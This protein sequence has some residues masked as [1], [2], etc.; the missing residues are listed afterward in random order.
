MVSANL[1]W[2]VSCR[3]DGACVL[4]TKVDKVRS[5]CISSPVQVVDPVSLLVGALGLIVVILECGEPKLIEIG[6]VHIS[7]CVSVNGCHNLGNLGLHCCH[8]LVTI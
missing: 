7:Q 4:T 3:G 2:E 8:T 1:E 5:G 6:V